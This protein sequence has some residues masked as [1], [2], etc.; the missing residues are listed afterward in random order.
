MNKPVEPTNVIAFP[1]TRARIHE[2]AVA[3]LRLAM[4]DLAR[5]IKEDNKC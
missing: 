2:L 3:D 1:L 4:I 5:V